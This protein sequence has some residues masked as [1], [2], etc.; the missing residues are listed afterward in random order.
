MV[1]FEIMH[2]SQMPLNDHFCR[3]FAVAGGYLMDDC[4]FRKIDNSLSSF[5][6]RSA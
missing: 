1:F 4:C 6:D 3:R 2:H 5:I